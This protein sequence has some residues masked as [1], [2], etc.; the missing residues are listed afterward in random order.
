MIW[1]SRVTLAERA[2][3]PADVVPDLFEVRI[4]SGWARVVPGGA[5]TETGFLGRAPSR[6]ESMAVA[7]VVASLD[8]GGSWAQWADA[9]P[10]VEDLDERVHLRPLE[11]EALFLL[12]HLQRVCHRPRLHLRIEEERVRVARARRVPVRAAASLVAH[13]AD[14][15]HRTLRG[16]QPSRILATQIDDEW[17]L[18][19]NRLA[20]RLVDHLLAYTAGRLDEIRRLAAMVEEGRDFQDQTDGSRFRAKRLHTLWGRFFDDDAMARELEHTRRTLEGLQ[21]SM[22]MLLDSPLYVHVNRGVFVSPVLVPTNILV[23]DTHY[24]KVAALWRAW[25][26]HG[27]HPGP[28]RDELRRRREQECRSFDLFA[29]LVVIQALNGLGYG[30]SPADAPQAGLRVSLDGPLGP[31]WLESEGGVCRFGIGR[32]HLRILPVLAPVD[33]ERAALVWA[34]MRQEAGSERDL[35]ILFPGRVEDLEGLEPSAVA[36]LCG[37]ARPGVVPISPWSLDCAERVARVLR[38]WEAIQR[39]EDY[40]PRAQVHPDPGVALPRWMSRVGRVVAVVEPVGQSE[41]ESFKRTCAEREVVS[42]REQAEAQRSGKPFDPGRLSA[43]GALA[44]LADRATEMERWI[45]CPVCPNPR[46]RFVSRAHGE[47][48][49]RWSWWCHCEECASAWGLRVCGACGRTYPVLAPDVPWPVPGAGTW[50][51]GMLERAFGRDLWAAP[52][53]DASGAKTFRCTWCER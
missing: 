23:N 6:L 1:R 46:A 7:Q 32:K 2:S 26:R 11:K 41:R 19:E 12:P 21:R 34:Q 15:E 33:R 47:E 27:H 50:P 29:R 9:V 40:P 31:A 17:D 25:V 38:S 44:G 42:K 51:A 10:V 53:P 45:V 4:P 14:W 18:Y 3:I 16:I 22:Q 8:A 24:R 37:W 52:R 43:L 48:W 49:G 13:P 36:A 20:A 5:P 28:T 39:F 35:L 30:P